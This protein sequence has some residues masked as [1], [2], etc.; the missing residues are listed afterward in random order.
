VKTFIAYAVVVLGI[1]VWIGHLL[2]P[3]LNLPVSLLIAATRPSTKT[4]DE[5]VE[6]STKDVNAWFFGPLSD[7]LI[8]DIIAHASL[9]I[10]SGFAALLLAGILFHFLSIHLGVIVLL[11]LIAWEIAPIPQ[12]LRLRILALRVT[13]MLAGWFLARWLF[14]F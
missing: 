5:I 6:A 7:M 14:S 8:G 4:S 13:G 2:G 10:L 9:D 11:I 12:R 3:I 1:P